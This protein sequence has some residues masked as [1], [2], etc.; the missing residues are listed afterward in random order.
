MIIPNVITMSDHILF[1]S[2]PTV[3]CTFNPK[4]WNHPF[5]GLNV[6]SS[7]HGLINCYAILISGYESI[8]MK[9]SY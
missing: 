3:I 5:G 6:H 4:L 2:F 7:E 8:S 9:G 1:M